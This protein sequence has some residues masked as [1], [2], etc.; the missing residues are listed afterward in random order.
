MERQIK[1][2]YD[3]N[4][5]Q[6]NLEAINILQ[7]IDTEVPI[8]DIFLLAATSV[9][10]KRDKNPYNLMEYL[11][12]WVELDKAVAYQ[13]YHEELYP[14]LFKEKIFSYIEVKKWAKH[15]INI[16]NRD[17]LF[18]VSIEHEK[19][20]KDYEELVS[21]IIRWGGTDQKW[22]GMQQ[23]YICDGLRHKGK[24]NELFN[25]LIGKYDFPITHK[26][27]FLKIVA[28][29]THENSDILWNCVIKLEDYVK[30]FEN[31]SGLYDLIPRINLFLEDNKNTLI[32]NSKIKSEEIIYI[33]ESKDIDPKELLSYIKTLSDLS[34]EIDYPPF[35]IDLFITKLKYNKESAEKFGTEKLN[36][37]LEKL[38][39][40]RNQLNQSERIRDE[41]NE[42]FLAGKM[43]F[44][45]FFFSDD[46]VE[47]FNFPK[48][49]EEVNKYKFK[50]ILLNIKEIRN[51]YK[52]KL[53]DS[54]L[55]DL[56]KELIINDLVNEA[57]EVVQKVIEFENQALKNQ[58]EEELQDLFG[59]ANW[60]YLKEDTKTLLIS[61]DIIYRRLADYGKAIDYSGA[62]LPLAKALEKE[63][64]R[65]F[66]EEYLAFQISNGLDIPSVFAD[67][68]P[69][70][71]GSIKHFFR[72]ERG[73]YLRK[74][75]RYF[76]TK[77]RNQ[78]EF[79]YSRV[80]IPMSNKP[81]ENETIPNQ[82]CLDLEDIK[83]IRD[84]VAHKDEIAKA[85]SDKCRDLMF[86]TKKFFVN[87]INNIS[88]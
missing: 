59:E 13:K 56:Q 28:D 5:A 11:K 42:L 12:E 55:D 16:Y 37:E 83:R 23:Y 65:F 64:Y 60:K 26:I 78:N 50:A 19:L 71:M 88:K 44:P 72:F 45:G 9:I 39:S 54:E 24:F 87:F 52:R 14:Q 67:S 29:N 51:N 48:L 15:F 41:L 22:I 49:K 61:A 25:I 30:R 73:E 7:Q 47:V 8:K 2:T 53:N 70:T 33:D 85:T 84:E 74:G 38:T 10:Y 4:S 18:N 31:A 58:V 68:R 79:R 43:Y 82:F 86:Q 32:K 27:A 80:H 57:N 66:Y 36:E 6:Q 81:L 20:M 17:I 40:I 21:E 1:D 63:L 46:D 76:R 3:V 62:T 75:Q 35:D 77:Y 34:R 69:F